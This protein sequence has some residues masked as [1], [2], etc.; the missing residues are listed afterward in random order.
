MSSTGGPLPPW[1]VTIRAPEVLISVRV[2]PSNKAM[3]APESRAPE[4]S[5]PLSNPRLETKMSGRNRA[6]GYHEP[7]R[8]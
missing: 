1:T 5:A 6:S 8:A 4:F 7:D 3:F 2:K